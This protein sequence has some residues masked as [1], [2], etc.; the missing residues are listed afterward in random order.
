MGK[1]DMSI[2]RSDIMMRENAHNNI[3]ISDVSTAVSES[4]EELFLQGRVARD[5]QR[6]TLLQRVKWKEGAILLCHLITFMACNMSYSLM[7]PF[8]PGE[9]KV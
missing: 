6:E 3:A 7:A 1:K 9:V 4:E 5:D 8:F 2:V